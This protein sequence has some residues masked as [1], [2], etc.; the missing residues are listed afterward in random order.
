MDCILLRHGIAEDREIWKGSESK[1]PLTKAG[2]RKTFKAVTGLKHL[3][4][5]PTHL[6]SSPYTRAWETA[7]IAAEIF[8]LDME[9]QICEE[10]LFDRS[11]AE[12]M[13]VLAKLPK[14]SCVVCVGH[15]PHLGEAAGVMI[16]GKAADSLSLKKAGACGVEFAGKPEAGT[17][18]L[19]WWLTPAQLR[20]LRR[21]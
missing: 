7:H 16:F 18:R 19:L 1:R 8:K 2:I 13:P 11:P 6:L 5:Q 21:P 17:G 3:G 20:Q 9:V 10:L 4:I 14:D 15:E 12:L